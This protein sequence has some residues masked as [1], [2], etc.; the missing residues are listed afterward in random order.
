M[1]RQNASYGMYHFCERTWLLFSSSDATFICDIFTLTSKSQHVEV[2]K[3]L[4]TSHSKHYT[5][6]LP[7]SGGPVAVELRRLRWEYPLCR[8]LR[9][10]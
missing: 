9:A 4:I 1:Y 7:A 10:E 6:A 8:G 3:D 5:P 2:H